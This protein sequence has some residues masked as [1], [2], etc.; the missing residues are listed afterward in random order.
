MQAAKLNAMLVTEEVLPAMVVNKQHVHALSSFHLHSKVVKTGEY[1]GEVLLTTT[2]LPTNVDARAELHYPP[3][4]VATI[5]TARHVN[6]T[7]VAHV[8][9]KEVVLFQYLAYP[10]H[11]KSFQPFIKS[12][13]KAFAKYPSHVDKVE[14]RVVDVIT[15]S[16]LME[17]L[18]M[19]HKQK[20]TI[21]EQNRIHSILVDTLD[22]TDA[23]A[24]AFPLNLTIPHHRGMFIVFCLYDS[25][26]PWVPMIPFPPAQEKAFMV[27][28]R[29][30]SKAFLR[31]LNEPWGTGKPFHRGIATAVHVFETYDVMKAFRPTKAQKVAIE[32]TFA[33]L[34]AGIRS[35]HEFT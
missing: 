19:N 22:F 26:N 13:M 28:M 8:K 2:P 17:S 23:T 33:M 35:A 31:A 21:A 3:I 11:A 32:N 4:D 5:L 10:Q 1:A 14:V 27:I 34:A 24:A 30:R 9:N 16:E 7:C 6:V 12:A 20:L 29:K 25:A 15:T 18:Y